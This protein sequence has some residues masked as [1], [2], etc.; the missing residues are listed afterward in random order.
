MKAIFWILKIIVMVCVGCQAEHLAV[1][2]GAS[3]VWQHVAS[4]SGMIAYLMFF[5][6]SRKLK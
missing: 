6:G 2:L 4:V 3:E 1:W 5:E